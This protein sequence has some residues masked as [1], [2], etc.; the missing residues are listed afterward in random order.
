MLTGHCVRFQKKVLYVFMNVSIM[1]GQLLEVHGKCSAVWIKH[2]N[3]SASAFLSFAEALLPDAAD[4]Q[5][6][7]SLG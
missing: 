1:E 7:A 3:I 6:N 4:T 5:I 2:F